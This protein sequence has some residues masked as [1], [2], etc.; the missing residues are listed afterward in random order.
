VIDFESA[1][2]GLAVVPARNSK[3]KVKVYGY[4]DSYQANT[5]SAGC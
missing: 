4:T 1:A 2:F 5:A 3:A